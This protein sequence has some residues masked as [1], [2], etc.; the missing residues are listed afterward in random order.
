MK[1]HEVYEGSQSQNTKTS[2]VSHIYI[3]T[4]PYLVF[5][6]AVDAQCVRNEEHSLVLKRNGSLGRGYG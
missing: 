4:N 3:H 5:D 6:N 2:E 1:G